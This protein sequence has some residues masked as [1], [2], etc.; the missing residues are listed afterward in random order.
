[1]SVGATAANVA[2]ATTSGW[3]R[4]RFRAALR[5]PART[6]HAILTRYV[7]ENRDTVIGRAHGFSRIP[8]RPA[9]LDA[10]SDAVAGYRQSMPI[11]TYDRLEPYI[12]RIAAGERHVLT[13]AEVTRLAPSS[14]STSAAKLVPHTGM[15]RRE[16]SVAVDAW[17][18][19]LYRSHP[20]ILGGPAYWSVT[21]AISF[22][23]AVSARLGSSSAPRAVPV[24]FDDDSAY[25]GGLRRMLVRAMLAVPDEVRHIDDCEAFRY[26]TLLFLLRQRRLRLISVW[27]PSF[28]MR[29]LETVPEWL[30]RLAGDVEKGTLS[31]PARLAPSL[32]SLFC[33]M[34][35]PDP[36]RAGELRR[37]SRV[38]ARDIWPDL[39]LVSCWGDGPAQ[40]Y[41]SRLARDVGGVAVQHKGL[42]ATEAIVTIPFAGRHPLA[43]HSHF[44][45][46]LAPDGGCLLP[47]ELVQGVEYSVLVTTGGGLYRYRLGDRVIVDGWIDA[48]PSLRLVGRDDRVSDRFGEK[49]SD[50]FVTG[51]L[52]EVLA[53]AAAPRFAMLAPEQTPEGFAYT[54][55]LEPDGPVPEGLAASLERALRRNPHY[56]WCVDLGQL[57]PARVVCVGPAAGRAY[58][59][60]CV[61]RGQRL[62]D[63]K[64]VSLHRDSGW[65]DALRQTA[66]P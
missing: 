49:L 66:G 33:S 58:V 43:I 27:H 42:I 12:R 55:L 15:L 29:L 41:A 10:S 36:S 62:G 16:F 63:V 44:F 9:A 21:P 3:A 54:L 39:A 23:A 31:S 40:A 7:R 38:S 64:P 59:D 17:M 53:R 37:L 51:V 19:D 8:L 30:D 22:D 5:N 65:E 28:L 60:I 1:M 47:H 52:A 34:L 46:F 6:Q 35:R 4:R 45:E 57:R 25:L 50:G 24:G 61:A 11:T 13:R 2:W 18:A 48:T 32:S 20:A 56:G 26:V 14:G